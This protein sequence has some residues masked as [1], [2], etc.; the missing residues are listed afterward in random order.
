MKNSKEF[1]LLLIWSGRFDRKEA[2]NG[3]TVGSADENLSPGD[4]RR[5]E[6]IT[7]NLIAMALLVAIVKFM[8]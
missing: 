7:G 3:N 8:R 5:N 1:V 4:H 2:K 6:F